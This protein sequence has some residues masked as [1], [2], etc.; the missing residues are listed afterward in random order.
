MFGQEHSETLV[1]MSGLAVVLERL[2]RYDE[3]E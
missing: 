2:R 3:A 1:S